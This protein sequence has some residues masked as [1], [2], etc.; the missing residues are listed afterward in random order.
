VKE[1]KA[2]Q[3]VTAFLKENPILLE[4]GSVRIVEIAGE[5]SV[6]GTGLGWPKDDETDQGIAKSQ[7]L[8]AADTKA[9]E[10]LAGFISGKQISARVFVAK[11]AVKDDAVRRVK[12]VFESSSESRVDAVVKGADRVAS[13]GIDGSK[14][15][16]V[17]LCIPLARFAQ[18][19]ETEQG[20]KPSA[21]GSPAPAA[22]G[23]IRVHA[24]GRAGLVGDN[25]QVAK[26]RAL[27]A[28]KQDAL[29][30]GVGSLVSGKTILKDERLK[31]RT[32]IEKM[33]GSI[34]SYDITRDAVDGDEYV[35]EIDA[36]VSRED[37]TRTA[38][39]NG[40]ILAQAGQPKV[41]VVALESLN[42]R[43]LYSDSSPVTNMIMGAFSAKPYNVRCIDMK[44]AMAQVK[45]QQPEVWEKYQ[46]LMKK[47]QDAQ[48]SNRDSEISLFAQ[49]G[50]GTDAIVKGEIVLK[51]AGKDSGGV[52][53]LYESM[54]TVRVVM[55]GTG[56]VLAPFTDSATASGSTP[57]EAMTNAVKKY[58]PKR[59]DALISNFVESLSHSVNN[60]MRMTV[61][62]SGFP[63]GFGGR[64]GSNFSNTVSDGL[65]SV[66]GVREVNRGSKMDEVFTIDVLYSGSPADFQRAFEEW[67]DKQFDQLMTTEKLDRKISATG[68]SISLRFVRE[69]AG[70]AP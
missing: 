62:F 41:A 21:A 51:D 61:S 24:V 25:K 49:L 63:G 30:K 13:W 4:D 50:V 47:L 59:L 46:S 37:L 44:Q 48:D 15:R 27:A 57:L 8:Q 9:R 35:V 18:G 11:S 34:K 7:A 16:G 52:M 70:Q 31:D 68:G 66:E 43:P 64:K 33:Q 28:A 14:G 17:M 45:I 39:A 38:E 26:N 58:D 20:T 6:V 56:E 19:G 22:D 10:A 23:T 5:E 53:N 36:E 60:G 40:V 12:S 3:A 2:D 55:T 32:V 54:L 67:F 65:K 42:G 29:Q 69:A 1:L